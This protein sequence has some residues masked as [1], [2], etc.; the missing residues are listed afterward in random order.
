MTTV[1]NEIATANS[2]IQRAVLMYSQFSGKR[3]D[4]CKLRRIVSPAWQRV[5]YRCWQS[6]TL[7]NDQQ[8]VE[9]LKATGSPLIA[10]MEA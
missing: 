7:Y 10:F 2:D 5:I 6:H 8:Y 3:F 1:N 4:D 9:R